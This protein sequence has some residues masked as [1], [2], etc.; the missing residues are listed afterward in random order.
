VN[1]VKARF[2]PKP[3]LHVVQKSAS[4]RAVEPDDLYASIDPIL[5]KSQNPALGV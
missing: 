1:N 5:D 4:R 3:K 2:G